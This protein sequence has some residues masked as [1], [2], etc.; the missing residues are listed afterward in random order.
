[1]KNLE[2][3]KSEEV[4]KLQNRLALNEF[5]RNYNKSESYRVIE[6]LAIKDELRGDHDINLSEE[7]EEACEIVRTLETKLQIALPE[8]IVKVSPIGFISITQEQPV[9]AGANYRSYIQVANSSPTITSKL[10]YAYVMG[11]KVG[12]RNMQSVV[13]Q[14]EWMTR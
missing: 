11:G 9:P 14:L 7:L 3:L 10:P 2:I 4:I 6:E 12:K 13:E 1:M 5:K 8:Y